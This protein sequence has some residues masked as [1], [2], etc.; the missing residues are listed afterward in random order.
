MKVCV[1]GIG[2]ILRGD[3]GIGPF[4]VKRLKGK[5]NKKNILWLDCGESP[6]N[7]LKTIKLFAPDKIIIIDAVEM[8]MSPGTV[9]MINPDRIK[10]ESFST[11]KL[12]LKLLLN[13]LKREIN[14]EIIFIGI[15]PLHSGFNIPMSEEVLKSVG[16]IEEL[17]NSLV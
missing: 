6:E 10:G 12:P 3:D 2:N 9:R 1:C 14:V 11:H 4:V 7:H 8:G 13:Y 15:Q 16:D 17:I 5:I